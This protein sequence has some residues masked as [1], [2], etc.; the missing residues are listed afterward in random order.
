[1][2]HVRLWAGRTWPLGWAA[3]LALLSHQVLHDAGLPG[4]ADLPSHARTLGCVGLLLTGMASGLLTGSLGMGGGVVVVP[5]LC[6]LLPLLGTPPEQLMHAAVATSLT[7]M[8]PT[9][10]C[11]AVCQHRLGALA[12]PWIRR[13]ALP[14]TLGGAVGALVATQV[15]GHVLVLVF[16]VQSAYYGWTLTRGT[17]AAS[18]RSRVARLLCRTPATPAGLLIA[19]ASSCA[20]M[21]GGTLMVPYL[22]GNGVPLLH[23]AATS[24]ALNLGIA[25]AGLASFVIASGAGHA[26]AL[27]IAWSAAACVAVAAAATVPVGARWAH[28]LPVRSLRRV[29]GT[30]TIASAITLCARVTLAA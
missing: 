16:A 9:A 17:P 25:S 13:L 23:A 24:S 2:E 21:G 10:L 27:P 28:A 11:A 18:L 29:L 3:A 5:L 19:A 7:A 4:G 8:V 30:V 20:G 12:M 15:H 6:L 1:M 22:L 26:A 14:M